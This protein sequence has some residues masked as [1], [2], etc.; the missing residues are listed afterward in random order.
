MRPPY[1]QPQFHG[2]HPPNGPPPPPGG[3]PYNSTRPRDWE[4]DGGRNIF[5]PD[6][7]RMRPYMHNSNN[8]AY[9]NNQQ[10]FNRRAQ[11]L[12]NNPNVRPSGPYNS[13]PPPAMM[14]PDAA[15]HPN[16]DNMPFAQHEGGGRFPQNVGPQ[17]RGPMPNVG[18]PRAGYD[19]N[20]ATQ[21][22]S[23]IP[24]GN[25][26]DNLPPPPRKGFR[27]PGLGP[28]RRVHEE[29][30]SGN[31]NDAQGANVSRSEEPL[32]FKDFLL[33]QPDNI[34]SHAAQEAYNEYVKEFTK[35]KP[36]KFFDEH[37]DEE[38][39]KERYDPSYVSKRILRIAEECRARG[40]DYKK[41]WD[42][43]GSAICAPVL[44]PEG[45]KQSKHNSKAHGKGSSE[46]GKPTA[47]KNAKALHGEG[48][49]S[50]KSVNVNGDVSNGK[51]SESN[52]DT[53]LDETSP[54]ASG[55]EE[56]EDGE[57]EDETMTK[58]EPEQNL[59][60]PL[61][62]DHQKDTIFMRCIPPNLNREDLTKV[63]RHGGDGSHNFDLRRLKLGDI[64]PQKNLERYG[65]A[66]YDSAE[67]ASAALEVVRGVRVVSNDQ[68]HDEKDVTQDDVKTGK[69]KSDE[70][71]TRSYVIDC[72]LNLERK[73]KFTQGRVLPSTFGTVDRMKFDVEQ[74]TKMMRRLD[75]MRHFDPTLNPLTDEFLGALENDG[76]RLDHIVSYLRE[77]HYFCYYSGNEFL[78]DPTSMPPQELRPT[79][80]R[81]RAL[82]EADM[83]LIKR[84]DERAAWVLERDYDR[85]RSNS[86]NAEAAMSEAVNKWLDDHTKVE[87][88]KRYRCAL[89]PN[90]LFKA[91]SFVHKHL[92][93][94]HAD[95]MNAVKKKAAL[96]VYK[97][98]FEND[99]SRDEVIKIYFEGLNGGVPESH[100][101]SDFPNQGMM[102]NVGS[103][104]VQPG[105]GNPRNMNMAQ[106][107]T[108]NMPPGA[109][110]SGMYPYMMGMQPF[111]MMMNPNNGFNGG[112]AG[113]P[114]Y[115]N[116]MGV[117]GRGMSM[118]PQRG[119][120][121]GHSG[122][123]RG[124]SQSAMQGNHRGGMRG[125]GRS[126]S[127]G[128]QGM[129]M[130]RR[131]H[132]SMDRG[133]R[134]T[135]THPHMRRYGNYRGGHRGGHRG[136]SGGPRDARSSDPRASSGSRR[137]YNDLDAPS[138]TTFDLVRYDDV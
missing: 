93:T 46:N 102:G 40:N 98:N 30:N 91:P 59:A 99:A 32:S 63:L 73:R 3:Q 28:E 16:Q 79:S 86:D 136:G 109:I 19:T 71:G 125:S 118:G 5:E 58:P 76:R 8:P 83:R 45:S 52:D 128:P 48:N 15:R 94:K 10:P 95:K 20:F 137:T 43:G 14:P 115:G 87:S 29:G 132:Y 36:N 74:S 100:A 44:T 113:P 111:P 13:Q 27:Q 49:L 39:F 110:P 131:P 129:P 50:G 104:F 122:M 72:M 80:D 26:Y 107:P 119:P 66:V 123:S 47:T 78:E 103:G 33:K 117:S 114:G 133:P 54:G 68:E 89:P 51:T 6:S 64:N 112:F 67:T 23:A 69:D 108:G 77:V 90:K 84:V 124:M 62:R 35:N 11:Q 127:Q 41:L 31:V 97:A 37:K 121:I 55:K 56:Q 70:E 116:P 18:A 42:V 17:Y 60:L 85:P 22:P 25:A 2:Q 75:S 138:N 57:A 34:S 106:V 130:N 126:L 1:P 81:G 7:K 38:W 101:G 61:R 9:P 53:V 92:R 21:M 105:Q 134:G 82:S 88:E 4:V 12:A 24:G 135:R 65:W 96:E 120:G